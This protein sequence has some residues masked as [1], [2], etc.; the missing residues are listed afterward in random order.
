MSTTTSDIIPEK[1]ES[2]KKSNELSTQI[3]AMEDALGK[4]NDEL[5]TFRNK[6]AD[7]EKQIG[8]KSQELETH[9][10]GI[11]ASVVPFFEAI[12]NSIHNGNTGLDVA[13]KN[14]ALENE[15]WTEWADI[16]KNSLKMQK[17]SVQIMV[18]D[19]VG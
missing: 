16:R 18:I 2:E 7:I 15:K 3:N 10:N 19:E 4:L 1:R 11:F 8:D 14:R 5:T 17:W 13:E 12:L 9:V 6:V